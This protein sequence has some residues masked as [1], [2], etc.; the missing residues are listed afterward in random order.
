MSRIRLLASAM[1]VSIVAAGAAFSPAQAATRHTVLPA[2][3]GHPSVAHLR[4]HRPAPHHRMMHH[5]KKHHAMTTHKK[6]MRHTMDDKKA[7]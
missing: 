6:P 5:G 1:V 7:M 4:G 3:H 2:V